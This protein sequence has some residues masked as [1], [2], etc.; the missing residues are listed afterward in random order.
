MFPTESAAYAEVSLCYRR[1][2]KLIIYQMELC[3]SKLVS[4]IIPKKKEQEQART[5]YGLSEAMELEGAG[6][7]EGSERMR[8]RR[9][10]SW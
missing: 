8:V 2:D 7:A 4:I 3:V 10:A 5:G 9:R 6:R 1:W